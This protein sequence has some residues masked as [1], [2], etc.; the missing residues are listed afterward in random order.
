L[1]FD[2]SRIDKNSTGLFKKIVHDQNSPYTISGRPF[3]TTARV[4]TNAFGTIDSKFN[5]F[6]DKVVNELIFNNTGE[7]GDIDNI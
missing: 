5:E 1:I 7:N 6:I 3:L 2:K 4:T